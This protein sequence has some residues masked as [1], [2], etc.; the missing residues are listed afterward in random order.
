MVMNSNEIPQAAPGATL[1]RNLQPAVQFTAGAQAYLE[2][3]GELARNV[4]DVAEALRGVSGVRLWRT[5]GAPRLW[6]QTGEI[7]ATAAFTGDK[8]HLE[9]DR[10]G[11]E[12]SWACQLTQ[13]G[14]DLAVLEV[15]SGSS[16]GLDTRA[17][18]EKLARIATITLDHG[19]D[20]QAIEYLSA[21]LEATK[22]LNSTLDLSELLDI[23]LQ[24]STTLCGA[25]RG[26]VFL[27]DRKHNEIWSLKGLGLQKHEIRLPIG[28]GI[29]GWVALHGD[30]VR[31]ADASSDPRFDPAVDRDLGYHTQELLAIPIRNKDAEIIG[32]LELLNKQSGSFVVADEEALNHLSIYLSVA[33]EKAQLHQEILAKQRIESDLE[34]A[35]NV[36]R[37]LLPENPPNLDGF[38]IGVA[39]VP[40]LMVGG[41]YYDFIRLKPD[42]LLTVVADVEGKGVA[43][44]LMMANLHASLRTLAAH[45]HSLEHVVKSV[46]EMIFSD[47][48]PHKLLSM[49]A[50]VVDQRNRLLH[51]INAGHV[52]PAVIRFSDETV[53][54]D[55]GGFLL[56]AFPDVTY[57]RARV[58]LFPGDIIVAYTDGIT[59]A[60]NIQGEQYGLQR[61]L[62]LLR[63]QR[64]LPAQHIVETV[65]A[66]VDRFSAQ[67]LHEDDRVLLIF[68]VS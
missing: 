26:T 31:T 42:S 64:A 61:L 50:A 47:S 18:L 2:L 41:D 44:A 43:A 36:Q 60:M 30:R 66:E 1:K 19:R 57:T 45:V 14:V 17:A 59:E 56:G 4:V 20:R 33:L 49:F 54:L 10:A 22:L 37:G 35:R 13:N 53:Q 65:L 32:V 21:I 51:Y 63:A 15:Y 67:G 6:F 7:P 28:K 38:E 23:I 40:S 52:P 12:R 62:S 39:Y 3:I 46:N 11:A 24:L 9:P 29:A 48:R 8:L 27:L 16:L 58:Q 55:E 34:L 5:D 68:K 25:D